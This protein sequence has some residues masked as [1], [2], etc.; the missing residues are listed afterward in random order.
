LALDV[1]GLRRGVHL[2]RDGL[3]GAG[4]LGRGDGLDVLPPRV[5]RDAEVA[6]LARLHAV[7]ERGPRLF[8]GRLAVPLVQL[9]EGDV[10]GA[11]A[12]QADSGA[13]DEVVAA[14]AGVVRT[15]AYAHAHLGGGDP[16]VAGVAARVADGLPREAG[17]VDVGRV[18]DV[19]AR[20]LG[21]AELALHAVDLE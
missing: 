12:A 6:H 11:E 1:A 10:C 3:R 14:G 9:V 7:V 17:G 2:I 8:E 19:D 21:E 16:V 20:V 15:D 18:D 5:V 13:L 4:P